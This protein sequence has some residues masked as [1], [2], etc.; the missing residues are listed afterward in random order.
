MI[1]PTNLKDKATLEEVKIIETLKKQDLGN[2]GQ[3]AGSNIDQG[4]V[5]INGERYFYTSRPVKITDRTCLSC[6]STLEKAPQ[7]LQILY[8]QGKYLANQ[9]FG[10]EF[11][12]VIGAKL[13]YVPTT[14][15]H[16]IAQRD[17]IILLGVLIGTFAVV[18]MATAKI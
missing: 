6:H 9:G 13:V 14:Q 3:P 4:Y 5:K 12:T 11:N 10:W 17:F 18:I 2:Q 8:K 16:K 7:S 15:V 1:N